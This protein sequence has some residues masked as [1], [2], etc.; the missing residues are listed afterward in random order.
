[1]RGGRRSPGASCATR[2]AG[3]L[4]F[5]C[6]AFGSPLSRYRYWGVAGHSRP[7][8]TSCVR[9]RRDA[10]SR[11]PAGHPAAAPARAATS[12]ARWSLPPSERFRVKS[13][14]RVACAAAP[15]TLPRATKFNVILQTSARP[16]AHTRHPTRGPAQHCTRALRYARRK[17]GS[18]LLRSRHSSLTSITSPL[19]ALAACCSVACALLLGRLRPAAR[20][21][22]LHHLP[23]LM[24]IFI[25]TVRR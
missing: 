16:S 22:A 17:R 7:P 8:A 19:L 12:A 25:C 18:A 9:R 2:N 15:T 24:S 20:S 10:A 11:D 13:F 6:G 21:R 23:Q 3:G 14:L 4:R 1:M 5:P